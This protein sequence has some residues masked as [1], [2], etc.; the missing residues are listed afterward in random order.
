[1]KQFP[2][3]IVI[4]MATIAVCLPLFASDDFDSLKA[5]AEQGDKDSQFELGKRYLTG[6]GVTL[7]VVEAYAY[8]KLSGVTL[9]S[10]RKDCDSKDVVLTKSQTDKGENRFK[11]LQ[12][13]IA[14]SKGE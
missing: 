9:E 4:L 14:K 12:A 6:N 11:E 2:A 13:Q 5:K 8:W 7:N 1:M 10:F 3:I